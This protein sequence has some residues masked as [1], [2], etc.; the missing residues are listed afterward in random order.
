M[1]KISLALLPVALFGAACS[2]KTAIA[3]EQAT[4]NATGPVLSPDVSA[5]A[6]PAAAAEFTIDD[7]PISN[8]PLAKFPFFGLPS[9]YVPQNSPKSLDFGHFPFWTGKA[10]KDV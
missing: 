1:K 3:T 7:V 2:Q 9:G 8:A 4:D 10:F 6:A 5:P